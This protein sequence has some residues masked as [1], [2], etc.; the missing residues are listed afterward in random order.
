MLLVALLALLAIG[1]G[2]RHLDAATAGLEVSKGRVGEIPVTLYRPA[3]GEPAPVVVIAHGFAGSQQLMQPFAV[4]LARNG[5]LAVTFD[6][7]GHGGNPTPFVARIEDQERRVAILLGALESVVQFAAG[8][9]GSDGRLAL[10]GH[11]M[12]GDVLLRLA[13]AEGDRVGATALVSPYL[14]PD[15]PTGEPRN[16]LI[17]FGALEPEMLHQVG[18]EAIAAATGEAVETG[19]TYGD[20]KQGDARRLMLVPGVEHIGVLYGAAGSPPPWIG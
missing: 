10:L 8:L 15:A 9:P 14:A 20:L 6:F 16:L 7:P 4:T 18:R 17:L 12:A 19:I 13:A 3:G 5:Y 11:S 1:T 2:L